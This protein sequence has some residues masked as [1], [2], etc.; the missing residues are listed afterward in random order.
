MTAALCQSCAMPM[1][2]SELYGTNSDGSQNPDYCKYC[3][4]D[5]A[6]KADITQEQMIEECVPH[7][8]SANPGMDG[9]GARAIMHQVFPSLKRWRTPE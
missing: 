1:E 8:L 2:S 4:E 5:G 6:F 9:E 3:Y 7:M